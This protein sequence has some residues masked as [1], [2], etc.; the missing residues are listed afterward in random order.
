MRYTPG[1]DV[2]T[3]NDR[4]DEERNGM[5]KYVDVVIIGSGPAGSTAAI[6]TARARL[7]TV[8][9]QGYQTGGQLMLSTEVDNF[10]GFDTGIL[11]PE[12]ME[13]LAAQAQRFGAE[14]VPEDAVAVDF[15]QSPVSR[16]NRYGRVYS[17]RGDRCHRSQCQMARPAQ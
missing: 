11:G 5:K 17:P 15:Q 2:A 4:A 13:C 9:L 16:E 1:K 7:S 14:L 3:S 12:L 10:P 6:Y 8:I